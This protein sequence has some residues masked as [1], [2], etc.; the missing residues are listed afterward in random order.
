MKFD[1]IGETA[2]DFGSAGIKFVMN[3]SYDIP[4][5]SKLSFFAFMVIFHNS[6]SCF[7]SSVPHVGSF[8]WLA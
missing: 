4:S 7:K 2:Y 3:I 8:T 5:K 6:K 1:E